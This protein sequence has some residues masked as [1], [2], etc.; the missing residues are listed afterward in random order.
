[1]GRTYVIVCL[2]MLSLTNVGLNV[3]NVFICRRAF[4]HYSSCE[5]K[6]T[7]FFGLPETGTLSRNAAIHMRKYLTASI[8]CS[9]ASI[10]TAG[11]FPPVPHVVVA[12]LGQNT[13][14]LE[15]VQPCG[16]ATPSS[17]SHDIYHS[18]IVIWSTI[19]LTIAL[20]LV[21]VQCSVKR[22]DRYNDLRSHGTDNA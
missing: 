10:A 15:D 4:K 14:K 20:L 16:S 1:M 11:F 6:S 22:I 8:V 12:I 18:L 5:N 9:G 19:A 3:Y 13:W 7:P 21:S 2:L 17:L